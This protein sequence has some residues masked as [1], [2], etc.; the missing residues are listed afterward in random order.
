MKIKYCV[1]LSLIFICAQI[2]AQKVI[3]PLKIGD[4]VSDV[5]IIRL[6]NYKKTSVNFSD[7]KGRLIILDFWATWCVPCIRDLP[8]LDSLQK[9]LGQKIVVLPISYQSQKIVEQCLKNTSSLKNIDLPTVYDD[10]LLSRLFPH[11]SVPHE[12]II[13]GNGVVQ[14]ITNSEYVDFESINKILNGER[15]YMPKKI[16][17]PNFSFDK[18]LFLDSSGRSILMFHRMITKRYSG[19]STTR[20]SRRGW[21]TNRLHNDTS[22]KG[23]N[24]MLLN[25][26]R[27]AL[28]KRIA[29]PEDIPDNQVRLLVKNDFQLKYPYLGTDKEKAVWSEKNAFCFDYSV[30]AAS[31]II[32][33]DLLKEDLDQLFHYKSRLDT[34]LIDCYVLKSADR[35]KF[36]AKGGYEKADLG[37]DLWT[38]RGDELSVVIENVN[39]YFIYP[40]IDE[41]HYSGK[42]DLVL[43]PSFG[44]IEQLKKELKKCGFDLE[45]VKR[46]RQIMTI[47]DAP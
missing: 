17:D 46:K 20:I 42:I 10:T 36:E 32:L 37:K 31:G 9:M 35:V 24:M 26:Y 30:P 25:I 22:L 7:F 14:A 18:P 21:K 47:E 43:K 28:L 12:V 34:M 4:K 39:Y 27:S 2:K 40:I 6:L 8:K 41:T 33:Y 15:I 23:T 11:V 5:A 44:N 19:F 3:S 38:F 29:G 16:V 45:K 1:L 13:D